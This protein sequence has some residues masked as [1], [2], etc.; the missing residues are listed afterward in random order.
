MT[1]VTERAEEVRRLVESLPPKI[2]WEI[3]VDRNGALGKHA[4]ALLSDA[5][6]RDGPSYRALTA[7]SRC[8]SQ[9]AA[10]EARRGSGVGAWGAARRK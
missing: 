5:M 10:N 4:P 2:R 7:V 1:D 8:R 3:A 6:T 9:R